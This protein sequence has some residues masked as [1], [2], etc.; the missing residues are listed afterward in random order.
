MLNI[1][2]LMQCGIPILRLSVGDWL[3]LQ[4]TRPLGHEREII[5]EPAVVL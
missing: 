4:E 2:T 1:A 5:V 3:E